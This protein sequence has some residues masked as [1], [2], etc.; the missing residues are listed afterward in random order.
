[1]NVGEV[2]NPDAFDSDEKKSK[3]TSVEKGKNPEEPDQLR[4]LDAPIGDDGVNYDVYADDVNT[5]GEKPAKEA[6][7]NFSA[8]D[9]RKR[10]KTE[11]FVNIKNADK[12]KRA[13]EKRNTAEEKR[14]LNEARRTEKAA[15]R[16]EKAEAARRAR[17][18]KYD[19]T[20]EK[21][22]TK[23]VRAEAKH[24]RKVAASERRKARNAAIR[25]AIAHFFWHSWHK[26]VTIAFLIGLAILGYFTYRS[27]VYY[28]TNIYPK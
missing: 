12:I 5:V 6:E 24:Q 11:F 21:N 17:K 9:I 18:Q 16:A 1:M 26:F 22:A 8:E 2:E 13:E 3:S 14:I 23:E 25:H 19:D 15:K 27:F 20:Q 10:K 7:M 4:D 28:Y